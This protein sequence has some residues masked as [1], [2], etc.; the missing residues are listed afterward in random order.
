MGLAIPRSIP[1]RSTPTPLPSGLEA[2]RD[3]SFS[4]TTWYFEEQMSVQIRRVLVCVRFGDSLAK[5]MEYACALAERFAAELHVLH[6][7][8]ETAE[9]DAAALSPE[10]AG[11]ARGSEAA[12]LSGVIPAAW[13]E[14]LICRRAVVFGVPWIAIT[15]YAWENRIDAIVLG[16]SGRSLL[17]RWL[18]GSV[19]DQV[20]H[21]APCPIFVVPFPDRQFPVS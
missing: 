18:W 9:P 21:H 3:V 15:R 13:E 19:A 4:R 12:V 14:R 5:T 16:S 20:V 10:E 1:S 6:V 8:E 11:Y 17:R 7:L 2:G